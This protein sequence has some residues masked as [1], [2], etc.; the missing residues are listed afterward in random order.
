[1][2]LQEESL[3]SITRPRCPFPRPLGLYLALAVEVGPG[4]NNMVH[5]VRVTVTRQ[6]TAKEIVK[7]VGALQPIGGPANL[8]AGE[9]AVSPVVIPL[10]SVP[11]PALGA[12]D[13]RVSA[14]SLVPRI[15]SFYVKRPPP[16]V[17]INLPQIIPSPVPPPTSPP[18]PN[19]EQRRHPNG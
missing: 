3:A 10:A 5:E 15:L 14:D 12:Y 6:S 2:C 19:R 9:A 16:G 17:A 4:E 18:K 13:V 11:I 1:M 7:V 8:E